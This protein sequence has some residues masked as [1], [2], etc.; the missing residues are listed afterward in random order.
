MVYRNSRPKYVTT[1]NV[2]T[3]VP[4]LLISVDCLISS[5][6]DECSLAA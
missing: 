5:Y 3:T 2:R 1:E 4:E 6:Y